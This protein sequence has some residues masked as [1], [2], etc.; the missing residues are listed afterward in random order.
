MSDSS[1]K[2]DFRPHLER[3]F[4]CHILDGSGDFVSYRVIGDGATTHYYDRHWLN[5]RS[6]LVPP[7]WRDNILYELRK[8]SMIAVTLAFGDSLNQSAARNKE[9]LAKLDHMPDFP[10]LLACAAFF[11]IEFML[12]D[13]HEVTIVVTYDPEDSK[14]D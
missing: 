2:I 4:Q 7:Y 8:Y 10:S 13:R 9:F 3:T 6:S 11:S 1:I 5:I 14:N 12:T